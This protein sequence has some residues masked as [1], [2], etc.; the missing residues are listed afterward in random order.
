MTQN[1]QRHT[2]NELISRGSDLNENGF[3][4]KERMELKYYF[5][6]YTIFR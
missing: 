3:Q 2:V 4:F 1:K 6:I 5:K